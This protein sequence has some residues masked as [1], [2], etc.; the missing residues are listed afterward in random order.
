MDYKV[1]E[2]CHGFRGQK[3]IKGTIVR[4]VRPDE[5]PPKWFVPLDKAPKEAPAPEP[6]RTEPLEVAPGQNR[7]VPG[8]FAHNSGIQKIDRQMTTDQVPHE[9]VKEPAPRNSP[10]A[11][12]SAGNAEPP[13]Q[14]Q[15]PEGAQPQPETVVETPQT[16]TAPADGGEA[17][18]PQA[19]GAPDG[20]SEAE[21][22]AEENA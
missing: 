5:K 12:Q 19:E 15:T 21:R 16:E 10:T 7:S 22:E 4:D 17:G 11:E 13:T 18:Q 2:T 8:G 1:V 20:L 3:W 14:E 9:G 6:H